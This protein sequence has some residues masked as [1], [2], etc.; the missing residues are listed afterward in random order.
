MV[1]DEE[2]NSPNCEECGTPEDVYRLSMECVQTE[3]LLSILSEPTISEAWIRIWLG[4][5]FLFYL[6][7]FY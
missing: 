3:P 4:T 2:L 1:I 5:T 6:L 7:G